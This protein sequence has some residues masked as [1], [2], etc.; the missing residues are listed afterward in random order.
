MTKDQFLDLD[1]ILVGVLPRTI[2]AETLSNA[3]GSVRPGLRAGRYNVSK[4][5]KN[6]TRAQWTFEADEHVAGRLQ[7]QRRDHLDFGRNDQSAQ[8]AEISLNVPDFA[9]Q[10]EDLREDFDEKRNG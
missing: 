5:Q 8:E 6:W 3:H 2:V 4:T 1:E 7:Q 9:H 10:F